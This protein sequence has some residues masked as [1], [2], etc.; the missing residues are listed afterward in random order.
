M[1]LCKMKIK[2]EKKPKDYIKKVMKKLFSL[3]DLAAKLFSSRKLDSRYPFTI[4]IIDDIN[5]VSWA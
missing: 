4:G 3:D 1:Q 5:C 2:E